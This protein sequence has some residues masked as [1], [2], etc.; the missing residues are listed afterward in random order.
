MI[1]MK[2]TAVI[3][4]AA[5][6]LLSGCAVSQP[7]VTTG[8]EKLET[9]PTV[10]QTQLTQQP[11]VTVLTAEKMQE[12]E[13]AWY[14][15]MNT[16]MD[17][18]YTEANGTVSDGMRYYGNCGGYDVLY[19]P[20]QEEAET[21]LVI[22]DVTISSKSTFVIYAYK[23]GQF[24][25]LKDVYQLGV[26]SDEELELIKGK[27]LLVQSKLTPLFQQPEVDAELYDL[28]KDAFL[29]QFVTEGDWSKNDL[30][31]V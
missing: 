19:V 30:S 11:Q 6:L 25:E 31:I 18:W 23:D 13:D 7:N 17:G 29:R 20:T 16:E 2:K 8:P 10:T 24:R 5:A 27:H 3:V 26:I 9:V 22:G 12:I 14:A 1:W 28:M 15:A 4:S 21:S